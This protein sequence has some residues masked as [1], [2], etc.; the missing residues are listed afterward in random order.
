MTTSTALFEKSPLVN[1]EVLGVTFEGMVEAWGLD[2][3][4]VRSVADEKTATPE[5][6]S[7]NEILQEWG[8]EP[9]A[10]QDLEQLTVQSHE[11]SYQDLL[12]QAV[13]LLQEEEPHLRGRKQWEKAIQIADVAFHGGEYPNTLG[14]RTE[15][16]ITIPRPGGL[17]DRMHGLVEKISGVATG[18]GPIARLQYYAGR[19]HSWF[20]R[21]PD[22][23]KFAVAGVGV[24]A[25]ALAIAGAEAVVLDNVHE[26]GQELEAG[27]TAALMPEAGK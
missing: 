4:A 5:A 3:V 27:L 11:A 22:G 21:L 8:M 20:N 25:V 7:S 6:P 1:S 9:L 16:E 13:L 10:D 17:K 14:F 15:P 19:A 18:H 12:A 24:S 26:F 23:Y 2:P